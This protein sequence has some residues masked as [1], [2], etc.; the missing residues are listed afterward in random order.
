LQTSRLDRDGIVNVNSNG[1]TA[2]VTIGS[3]ADTRLDD[4]PIA[5]ADLIS[6]AKS[7]IP[8]MT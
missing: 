7:W 5:L 1:L 2:T 6:D 8:S 3:M 4:L